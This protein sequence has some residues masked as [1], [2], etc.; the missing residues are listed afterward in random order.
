MAE[1]G[2]QS[3]DT[4]AFLLKLLDAVETSPAGIP[5]SQLESAAPPIAIH[6]AMEGE[7]FIFLLV[8]GAGAGF[9]LFVLGNGW[10]F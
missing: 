8:L 4:N 7:E 9:L 2:L 5:S 3:D 10:P 1:L 6:R